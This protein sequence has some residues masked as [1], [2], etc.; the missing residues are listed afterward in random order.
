MVNKLPGDSAEPIAAVQAGKGMA[1]LPRMLKTLAVGKDFKGRDFLPAAVHR[2]DVPVSGCTLFARTPEALAFLNARF[3]GASDAALGFSAV[4]P[5]G[6]GNTDETA[7]AKAPAK[8]ASVEKIYWAI[9]EIPQPGKAQ[10]VLMAEPGEEGEWKHWIKAGTGENKS[11]AYDEEDPGRKPGLLR[12]RFVGAGSHYL[13]LEI[14]L[15]TGRHHQIRAQLARM[16]LHIKGDLK[17][18]AKRSER[19]GGIRLHGYSLSFPDPASVRNSARSIDGGELIRV[20]A[21]PLLRDPLWE[22]FEA[23]HILSRK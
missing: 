12:Y 13:F 23:A 10:R 15:L 16:G 20:Q 9:V 6:N 5:A 22:A 11:I 3:R 1:D 19:G 17:Y 8:A 21:L 7:A 2:L 14:T 4:K 18:G